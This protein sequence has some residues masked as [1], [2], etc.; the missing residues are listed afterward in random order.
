M[1]ILNFR[2]KIELQLIF[3][4]TLLLVCVYFKILKCTRLQEFL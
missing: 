4:Y 3:K 2:K 1:I